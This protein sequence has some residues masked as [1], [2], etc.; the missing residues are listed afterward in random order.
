MLTSSHVLTHHP[1]T[2]TPPATPNGNSDTT[3]ITTTN[4][5]NTA[6]AGSSSLSYPSLS[7]TPLSRLLHPSTPLSAMFTLMFSHIT[8]VSTILPSYFD[9]HGRVEPV[10][11]AHA[12]MSV[13]LGAPEQDYFT[14]L[15]QDEK[16]MKQFMLAMGLSTRRVPVTGVYDVGRVLELAKVGGKEREVVWVDVGGGDGHTLKE[17]LRVYGGDGGLKASHCVVQ[18]LEE[19]VKAAEEKASEDGD[20]KGVKWV[21]MD[22]LREAPVKGE[23]KQPTSAP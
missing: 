9:T 15:K 23:Y 11:P 19:V 1:G 14:L 6:T 3:N 10:G 13:L 20:L 2:P 17:F 21:P 8:S 5:G 16:R 12:P 22:F 7:H 4:N 18:D